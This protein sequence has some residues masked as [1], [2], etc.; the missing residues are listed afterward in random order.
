LSGESANATQD[1]IG[2]ILRG[3]IWLTVTSSISKVLLLVFFV[4]LANRLGRERL[5]RFQFLLDSAFMVFVFLD[6]G[7]GYLL[8]QK[9]SRDRSSTPGLIARFLGLRVCM[10]VPFLALYALFLY[11]YHRGLRGTGWDAPQ[12]LAVTYLAFLA[13][14]DI[15]RS[16]LRGWERMDLEAIS[17][18]FERLIYMGVGTLFLWM[19]YRLG[20]MM[21]VA[22]LSIA[23]S[24]A[25]VVWWVVRGGGS[26]R[27]Q[28]DAAAWPALIR[29]TLPFGLGALCIVVL[30]REDTVMLNWLKGDA[31]TGLYS[32][33]FRLMEGTL[34][35]PQAV[36]LAA[37]P[38]FSRVFHEGQAVRPQAEKIQ[39]WLLIFCLPLMAGGILLA[40]R[41]IALFNEEYLPSIPVLQLLLLALPALYLNYLVGTLLRSVDRQP[42]NLYSAAMALAV[43]FGMN[44]LLIPP[45]GAQGAA[46][47]TALTQFAYFGLMYFF[48]RGAIGSLRLRAY[49]LKLC[50]CTGVMA[51]A[52][53]PVQSAPLYGSIP[54]GASVFI[55]IALLTGL[56]RRE[57]MREFLGFL[58]QGGRS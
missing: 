38:T 5:G 30:Y 58:R 13:V 28:L 45:L 47:A 15:L 46:I 48:L 35:V 21:L 16:V 26:F 50:L 6:L 22:Q 41:V 27:V 39:R 14:W 17:T 11:F 19:G 55:A 25:L 37:Y 56:V 40:P 32:S 29:E 24:L 1:P 8:V 3:S 34:L 43:N 53:Y 23:C 7:L 33:A 9:I 44:L 57:E 18:L 36:A 10:T 42:L 31:E 20:G 2:K 54:L 51:A 52:L 12:T 49:F 4:Y